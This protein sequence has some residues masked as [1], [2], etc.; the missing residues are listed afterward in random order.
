MYILRI[1]CPC[2]DNVRCELTKRQGRYRLKILNYETEIYFINAM[3]YFFFLLN[4][5]L[6]HFVYVLL[7]YITK[8]YKAIY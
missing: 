5:I 4:F 2:K 8:N 3:R 7:L 6:R 1:E